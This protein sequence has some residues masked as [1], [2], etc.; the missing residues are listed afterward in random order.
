VGGGADL[1]S[2]VHSRHV[3]GAGE[4]AIRQALGGSGAR[5]AREDAAEMLTLAGIAAVF[6]VAVDHGASPACPA[7]RPERLAAQMRARTKYFSTGSS[8]RRS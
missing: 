8:R 5:V 6:G 4:R 1:S 7:T 2:L 3:K